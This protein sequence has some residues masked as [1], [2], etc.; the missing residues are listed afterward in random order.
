MNQRLLL[1]AGVVLGIIALGAALAY[2]LVTF[3]GDDQGGAPGKPRASV[4]PKGAAPRS[5]PKRPVPTLASQPQ[6]GRYFQVV[7]LRDGVELPLYASPGGKL[8]RS[9][10]SRSEFGSPRVLAVA[11]EH[12]AWLGVITPLL[13]DGELGWVRYDPRKVNRYWTRYS[14]RIVLSKRQMQLRYGDR[15]LGRFT[16][17][18]GTTASA[19]PRGRFA[20]TDALDFGESPDYGCCALALSGHQSHLP[21]G[22]LGGDRIAIH[23]TPGPVGEADSHGCIRATDAAMHT[24]FRRV[25]LGTPVFIS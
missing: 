25:P 12:G 24:L 18:I 2:A 21:V 8:L 3:G 10:N 1:A 5:E 14:L 6:G 20:V 22:W 19:T 11:R 15:L 17:T 16:V 9:I 4:S 13:P 7:S 23:G